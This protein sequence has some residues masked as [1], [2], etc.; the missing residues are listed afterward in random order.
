MKKLMSIILVIVMVLSLGACGSSD[1]TEQGS[2]SGQQT[3]SSKTESKKDTDKEDASAQAEPIKLVVWGG[4]PGESGPQDLVDAW[5]A[6]N[7]MVQVEYVRFVNDDTG[8]TKLETAILSGEQIDLFFT[9]SMDKL[10]NR[11]DGGMVQDLAEFGVNGFIETEVAGAGI[12]QVLIDDKYYGLPTAKEPV[13]FMINKDMLDAVGITIPDNWTIDEFVEIAE[14]LSGEVDGKKVY[15]AHGYYAG[16]PLDMAK[17]VIGPNSYYNEDGSASGFDAPEYK[18][19]SKVKYLMD[20]G[21]A[22]PYEEV[23]SRKLEAYAHPAFLNGEVAMMPFSAWMLRYVKDLENFPHDFVTTF[24]PYPTT[25]AGVDNSYQAQL[26][27]HLCMS[28]NSQ[29]KDEAWQFMDYWITEGSKYMLKAGKIPV[30]NQA[31]ENEV[32]AAILGDQGLFDEAGYKKVMMN[33]DLKFIVDTHTTA[34]PQ[35]VKIFKDECSLYFLGET[36][37]ATFFDNLKSKADAAIAAK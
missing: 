25:E 24:A 35:V 30:W 4:V 29:Y 26:N 1:T 23:F 31:D 28:A 14:Q 27:N 16:L 2:D 36:D 13:G 9:Y 34:M 20:N 33:N 17:P 21:Y 8:N 22:L 6:E 3:E 10:K 5:N 18:A 11:V 7:P 19:I 15:G 32:A 37:E 12:G